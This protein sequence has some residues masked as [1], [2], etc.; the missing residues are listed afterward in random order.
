MIDLR[1]FKVRIAPYNGTPDTNDVW[2]GALRATDQ[3]AS[4]LLAFVSDWMRDR[5]DCAGFRAIV[6]YET[7]E[8]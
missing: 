7:D 2:D 3:L 5:P 6:E 4:D 8:T 1:E